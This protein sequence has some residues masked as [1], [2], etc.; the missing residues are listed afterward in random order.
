MLPRRPPFLDPAFHRIAKRLRVFELMTDHGPAPNLALDDVDL[1]LGAQEGRASTS[2]LNFYSRD[3]LLLG[4]KAYG[5]HDRLVAM[6]LGEY[7]L[8][9]TRED[10]FHH[11][12]ELFVAKDRHDEQRIM[13]LRVHLRQVT[14]L[15]DDEE[16]RPRLSYPVLVIEWLAMQNPRGRF[17]KE[18]PR[19]P[20]QTFPGSGLG[21]AM[22]NIL[23]IMA[24]RTGRE[25]LLNVPEHFH[26]ASLYLRA[27]YRYAS[28]ERER[29]VEAVVEVTEE[30]PFAAAAWAVERGFVHEEVDGRQVPWRYSP[31]ELLLPLSSQLRRQLPGLL[32]RFAERVLSP[33]SRRFVVDHEGF[34]ASLREDPVEGLEGYRAPRE[35]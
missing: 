28:L 11:R 1:A 27:G 33:S 29:E 19:L 18:R 6:G 10:A 23:V 26:L 16:P 5:I 31:E 9:V 15:G 30:L 22:H 7:E 13:D 2:F 20:G 3:G 21:R 35:G 34:E 32:E 25:A 17:T 14:W 24:E 8:E 12:L 4:M